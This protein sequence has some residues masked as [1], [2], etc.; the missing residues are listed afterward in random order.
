MR[1]NKFLS[2]GIIFLLLVN[3][4][5]IGSANFDDIENGNH[6]ENDFGISYLGESDVYEE[7]ATIDGI[8]SD[9]GNEIEVENNF[10][11]IESGGI[12]EENEVN[13]EEIKSEEEE[14]IIFQT[15]SE[16]EEDEEEEV[17]AEEESG[18]EETEGTNFTSEVCEQILINSTYPTG[19]NLGNPVK[20]NFSVSGENCVEMVC[21]FSLRN[22]YGET[23]VN[24][25]ESYSEI[26]NYLNTKKLISGIYHWDFICSSEGASNHEF[27]S[28]SVK[29]DIDISLNHKVYLSGENVSLNLNSTS[30]LTGQVIVKNSSGVL[31]TLTASNGQINLGN[32]SSAGSYTV[33]IEFDELSPVNVVSQTFSVVTY[34]LTS[35]KVKAQTGEQIEFGVKINSPVE[36]ISVYELNFSSGTPLSGWPDVNLVDEKINRSYSA[37]GNYSLRLI[38]ITGGRIFEV[39]KNGVEIYAQNSSY[40]DIELIYPHDNLV[41]NRDY[42]TLEFRVKSDGA[43]KNC[44]SSLYKTSIFEQLALSSDTLVNKKE[45]KT[46]DENVRHEIYITDLQ[47]GTYGWYVKCYK[48]ESLSTDKVAYFNVSY[49]PTTTTQTSSSSSSSSSSSAFTN[50]K[51]E[52]IQEV[53]DKINKFLEDYKSFSLEEREVIDKLNILEKYD[54]YKR[55]LNQINQDLNSISLTESRKAELYN[56]VDTIN[57]DVMSKVSILESREYIK[58]TFEGDMSEIITNYFEGNSVKIEKDLLKKIILFNE[59]LQKGLFIES[60]LQKIELHYDNNIEKITLVTKKGNIKSDEKRK[61]L[62]YFPEEITEDITFIT[63]SK[64]IKDKFF[65][66]EK[67]ESI[68]YYLSGFVDFEKL[69]KVETIL[70]EE[71]VQKNSAGI[72]GSVVRIIDYTQYDVPLLIII[73]LIL[74]FLIISGILAFRRKLRLKRWKEEPNFLRITEQIRQANISLKEGDLESARNDYHKIQELYVLLEKDCKAYL[75]Q[76][77]KEIRKEIDKKDIRA[78]IKEYTEAKQE[79]R[80]EDAER[81]YE[82]IKLIYKRLPKKER[83]RV[84]QKLKAKF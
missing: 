78:L 2:F 82:N 22:E 6:P 59:G 58:N 38:F 63:K 18:E 49:T 37:A 57:E 48:N 35:N 76:K 34:E 3:I 71:S 14:I 8:V 50:E 40:I 83:E 64:K 33:E 70:F 84:Y 19:T 45:Y 56:E 7:V 13:L 21:S 44:T 74:I 62:E 60:K 75:Y 43:I 81:L 61:V 72:T 68:V 41:I 67:E 46:I 9:E 52:E 39:V 11:L 15:L 51:T 69:N 5:S 25:E 24:W 77:I 36:K 66:I 28:F 42:I 27:G 80:K 10:D 12:S 30:N 23:I 55:R 16:E 4:V 79:W 29:E 1:L 26:G 73:L 54:I 31:K 32:F 53:L 20:F 17:L 65:E 47:P